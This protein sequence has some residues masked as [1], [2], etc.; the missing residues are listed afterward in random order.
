M[1][2]CRGQREEEGAREG[3]I[4]TLKKVKNEY[5]NG[6]VRVYVCVSAC[7][8]ASSAISVIRN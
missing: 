8:R 7:V 2:W 3:R 1:G 4:N 6:W 5:K